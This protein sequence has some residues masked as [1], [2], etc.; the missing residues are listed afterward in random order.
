MKNKIM[1][2]K[3]DVWLN[4]MSDSNL[5][6]TCSIVLW[7]PGDAH[8]IVIAPAPDGNGAARA[9]QACLRDSHLKPSDIEHIN[10]HATSTQLGDPIEIAAICK[11]FGAHSANLVLTAV[12]GAA[13][14]MIG[15][16]G[17][18]ESLFTLLSCYYGK[19]P[20]IRNL[21]QLDPKIA[22]IPFVPKFAQGQSVPWT[23]SR[24]VALKNSFGFG[25][26]NGCLSFSN[27]QE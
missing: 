19:I 23:A 12:K 11:V 10:C 9:I 20:P 5:K 22:K 21:F 7:L 18:I 3:Q 2:I 14:H 17:A 26:T 24:R 6:N 8:C 25:G 27:F 4:E 16:T 15:A 1:K 13:G